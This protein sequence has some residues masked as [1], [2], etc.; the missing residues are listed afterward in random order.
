MRGKILCVLHVGFARVD[1]EVD[2]D[3]LD[4]PLADQRQDAAMRK[5]AAE[6]TRA[7]RI[8]RDAVRKQEARDEPRH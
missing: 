2:D 6:F 7:Y 5:V 8:H 1:F 3:L 4:A